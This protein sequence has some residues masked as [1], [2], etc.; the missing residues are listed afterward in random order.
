MKSIHFQR[1]SVIFPLICAVRAVPVVPE[2][3][4]SVQIIEAASLKKISLLQKLFDTVP[5]LPP[6]LSP[7]AEHRIFLRSSADKALNTD[8]RRKKCQKPHDTI[9]IFLRADQ[10]KFP[11]LILPAQ[12][13][14]FFDVKGAFGL[15]VFFVEYKWSKK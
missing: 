10:P 1:H 14:V 11:R 3:I 6:A 2:I 7:V 13:R 15:P 8:F 4:V 12:L 9:R 5:D